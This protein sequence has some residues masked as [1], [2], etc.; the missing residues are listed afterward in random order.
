M[1][2]PRKRKPKR[3]AFMMQPTDCPGHIFNCDAFDE[4]CPRMIC[5]IVNKLLNRT[6]WNARPTCQ[7]N[8]PYCWK[9][10]QH[11]LCGALRSSDEAPRPPTAIFTLGK[12]N[13]IEI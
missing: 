12:T 10:A 3:K 11:Q 7:C 6:Q 2:F 5:Q 13:I 8:M 9:F 4:I 1:G